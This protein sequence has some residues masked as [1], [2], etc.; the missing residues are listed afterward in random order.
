MFGKILV[1]THFGLSLCFATWAMVLYTNRVNWTES[2]KPGEP[3]SEMTP[4]MAEYDRLAKTGVHPADTRWR[5]ARVQVARNEAGRP[6]EQ[7]WYDRELAFLQKNADEK[8]PVRQIDRGA[9]GNPVVL[10]NPDPGGALLQMGPLKDVAG[11]PFKGRDNQPVVLKSMEY[12]DKEYTATVNQVTDALKSLQLQ[13]KL[14]R[15]ATNKLK[16]PRGL[17][18]RLQLELVKQE[19]IKDE[20]NEIRPLWLNTAVELLNLQ[21]LHKRLEVRFRELGSRGDREG[22]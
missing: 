11:Q 3:E 5:G 10:A 1:F 16:G 12:Y 8:T 19:R 4:R 18:A 13:A 21:E 22:R 6:L 2:K 20:F 17:Q 9:D 15:D 7:P 14:D